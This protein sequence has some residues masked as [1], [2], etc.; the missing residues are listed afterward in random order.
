MNWSWSNG[1]KKET[2]Q[3]KLKQLQEQHQEQTTKN[4]NPL[5]HCTFSMGNQHHIAHSYTPTKSEILMCKGVENNTVSTASDNRQWETPWETQFTRNATLDENNGNNKREHNFK[6]IVERETMV[7]R[8][9]N[10]FLNNNNYVG[11][12]TNCESFLKPICCS[13]NKELYD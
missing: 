10:P 11:D 12:I 9:Q 6:K 13:L 2:T 8:S 5:H 3:R 7:Q 4:M 1:T